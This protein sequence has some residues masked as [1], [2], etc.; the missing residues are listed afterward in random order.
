MAGFFGLFDYNKPGP[1]VPENA[2]PK[3]PFIVFFEILQRKFWNLIKINFLFVIFDLP[4]ILLGYLVLLFLFPNIFPDALNSA[5]VMTS[6]MLMKFIL[7]MPLVCVPMVTVGPAQ[8]G[9][10]YI[11]RNYARE[12]HAFIWSD[13]KETALKNFKQGMVIGTINFVVT[14]LMLMSIRAYLLIGNGSIPGMIGTAIMFVLFGV[15]AMM[16][17]YIYPILITF[18]LSIK[19]IYKN[20]VIFAVVKFLPNLGI[21]LLSAFITFL[22]FGMIVPFNQFLGLLLLM[23]ITAS[24]VG[25]LTNFY[26]YPKL[27]KYMISRVEDEED[28][29]DDEDEEEDDDGVDKDEG[30]EID[31]KDDGTPSNGDNK[32]E[33]GEGEDEIKRYF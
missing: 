5:E 14:F 8:A 15:F 3:S 13:F 10:T 7:L 28:D 9:F 21:L 33:G 6:D 16:N 29:D 26:A 1:G 11:L 25:F 31:N 27:K 24:L 18:E 20:A 19:Q 4:A 2:P 23:L 32:G 12:E 22:T 30:E 17:I